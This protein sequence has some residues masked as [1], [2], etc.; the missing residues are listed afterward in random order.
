MQP[1][2]LSKEQV[3]VYATC[4]AAFAV[5]RL[6]FWIHAALSST[7]FRSVRRIYFLVFA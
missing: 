4:R 1:V 2:F 5:A 6:G 7:S 3:I